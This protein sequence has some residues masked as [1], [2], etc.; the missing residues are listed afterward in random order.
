MFQSE[1]KWS[2]K[3]TNGVIVAKFKT[4]Q[5]DGNILIIETSTLFSGNRTLYIFKKIRRFYLVEI[6][7]TDILKNNE[8]TIKQG[9]FIE[10]R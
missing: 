3:Q 5:N 4:L 6:A 8:I 10:V 1:G 7:F 2:A 9:T